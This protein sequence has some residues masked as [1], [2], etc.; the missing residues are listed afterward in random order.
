M[1][2]AVKKPKLEE[3]EDSASFGEEAFSETDYY[4]ENGRQ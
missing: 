3:T 2:L 4:F 1:A